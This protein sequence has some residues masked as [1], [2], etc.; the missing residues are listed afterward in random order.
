M[1]RQTWLANLNAKFV[2]K[3]FIPKDFS[4]HMIKDFM[5]PATI[6]IVTFVTNFS[7]NLSQ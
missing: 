7:K 1:E 3:N 5:V 2:Q 6:L 4:T